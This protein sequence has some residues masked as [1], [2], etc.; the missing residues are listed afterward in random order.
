[1]HCEAS[2]L[3]EPFMLTFPGFHDMEFR[4]VPGSS[5]GEKDSSSFERGQL[6]HAGGKSVIVE[7]DQVCGGGAQ[8][9]GF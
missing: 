4:G 3:G 9:V 7:V 2:F 1:M 5:V 8:R 6:I